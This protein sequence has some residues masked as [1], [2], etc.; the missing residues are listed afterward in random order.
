MFTIEIAGIPI[1]ISNRFHSTKR[2]F[3]DYLSRQMPLINISVS[4]EE[5]KLEDEQVSAYAE[6][7]A[8][9]RKIGL[10]LTDYDA[11]LMHAAIINVDGQG[12]GF[13]AQSGTGKST[14]VLLWK[15]AM[16]ER[17]DVVNGDK[18]ILRFMQ[19][20]LYAY[21]TPWMG[22]EGWGKNT[23]V[24]MKAMCFLERGEDVSLQRMSPA[25]VVPRL[26]R[27]IL[28]PKDAGRMHAYMALIE[29]FAL[30]VPCY[31]LTCN[32]DKEKPIEIWEQI[33]SEQT[34]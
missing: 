29:R 13:T 17:V 31:L 8:I 26:L 14:R 34:A 25:E 24:P 27:Q 2:M 22:K 11:F 19:N 9:V 10:F 30:T 12:I 21:G 6:Q 15:K 23:R 16:G 1:S 20:G 4:E 32:M 18:P 7:L 5:M 28:I 3:R 33:Q